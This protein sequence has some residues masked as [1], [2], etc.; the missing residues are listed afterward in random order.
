LVRQSYEDLSEAVQGADLL[1]GH[2][3]TFAA[4]MVA[5]TKKLPWASSLLAPIG[6][7][8]A[9]DPPVPAPAPWM[10]WMR[11]LGPLWHRAWF[12]L[13][14]R[15][16]RSWTRPCDDLRAE[17]GL[18]PRPYPLFE[19]QHAPGLVLALFSKVL[20]KPQRDWPAQT[21][22]TGFPFF[23][24]DPT[25]FSAN[26]LMAFLDAGPPPLVFTLGTSAVMDAGNFYSESI[27]AAQSLGKRAVLLIGNRP[28]NL[29]PGPLP[30][31]ILACGY[32]PHSEL[33]P[34]AA[35]IVHQ[36]GVGTTAQSLRAGKPMVVVP[37]AH[38]QFDNAARVRRLGVGRVLSRRRYWAARVALELRRF[39]DDPKIARQAEAIGRQV[40]AENGARVAADALEEFL[41]M[42]R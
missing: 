38:D 39:L 23:D 4:S 11:P 19:D 33:F 13:V 6:F 1:V 41:S 36:G 20:G 26:E 25:A 34:R 9:Y 28:G 12:R 7:V 15:S 35:A 40:R 16:F 2:P 21:R 24:Q 37:F 17:L 10:E 3:L 31:G 32:A 14:R 29:P 27:Q 30:D 8:S 5:E 22:V 18:P 42:N